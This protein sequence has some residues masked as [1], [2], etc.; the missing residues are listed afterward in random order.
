[1]ELKNHLQYPPYSII[2]LPQSIH[3]YYFSLHIH[4]KDSGIAKPININ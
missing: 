1:M 2:L 4:I 3:H